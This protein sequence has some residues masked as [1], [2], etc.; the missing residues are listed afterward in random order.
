MMSL[1]IMLIECPCKC[2]NIRTQFRNRLSITEINSYKNPTRKKK[3]HFDILKIALYELNHILINE[4][5]NPIINQCN[6]S[7][8]RA[9]Y[10]T[11][12]NLFYGK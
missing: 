12:M 3:F 4:L 11:S 10:Q 6:S 9:N 5:T 8:S 2:K 1:S 7:F